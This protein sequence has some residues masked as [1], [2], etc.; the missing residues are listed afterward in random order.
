[1]CPASERIKKWNAMGQ[2][3]NM[4]SSVFPNAQISIPRRRLPL[5]PKTL[6]PAVTPS[7]VHP[8]I[9]GVPQT[10]AQQVH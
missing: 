6:S 2:P 10:I 4:V 8:R 1:M 9:K 3:R 7:S 5:V